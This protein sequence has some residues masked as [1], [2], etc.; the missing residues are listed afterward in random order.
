MILLFNIFKNF[1]S[2]GNISVATENNSLLLAFEAIITL[3]IWLK[4]FWII[5][6][7]R[8]EIVKSVIIILPLPSN[9]FGAEC[10]II[11]TFLAAP[12]K[13]T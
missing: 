4:Y 11:C 3:K 8:E 9:L 12:L 1:S 5:F 2:P 13:K 10:L 7:G 6:W